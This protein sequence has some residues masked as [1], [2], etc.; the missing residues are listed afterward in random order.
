MRAGRSTEVT[1]VALGGLL[2]MARHRSATRRRTR[3]MVAMA[4][5]PD[6]RHLTGLEAG[7]AVLGL[8][9]VA[10][11][12]TVFA[13]LAARARDYQGQHLFSD[14]PSSHGSTLRS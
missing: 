6:K 10:F 8:T 7:W 11:V 12:G 13:V 9:L 2:A 1:M 4:A 5:G 14:M 3:P